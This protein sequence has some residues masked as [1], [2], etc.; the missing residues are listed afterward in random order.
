MPGKI[1]LEEEDLFWFTVSGVQSLA[2]WLR[3]FGPEV[4]QNVMAESL[5]G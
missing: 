3:R 2:G 5:E 4:R 1:N